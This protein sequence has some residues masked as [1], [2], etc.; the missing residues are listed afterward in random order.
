MFQSMSAT[1]AYC[2]SQKKQIT[3]HLNPAENY[4][5]YKSSISNACVFST[6]VVVIR[7]A[8][9]TCLFQL[10]SAVSFGPLL[11]VISAML[12]TIRDYSCESKMVWNQIFKNKI[13]EKVFDNTI[14]KISTDISDN[15]SSLIY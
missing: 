4:Q 15:Y 8:M 2:A 5:Y 3:D 1:S 7:V 14:K 10:Q 12:K 13:N 6:L 11:I 9:V